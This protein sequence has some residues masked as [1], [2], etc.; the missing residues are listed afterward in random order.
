LRD[1]RVSIRREGNLVHLIVIAAER[2]QLTLSFSHPQSC[3]VILAGRGEQAA[4][5]R[6]AAGCDLAPLTG[7]API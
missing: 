1:H 2:G 7:M 5:A 3:G 6:E 4:R